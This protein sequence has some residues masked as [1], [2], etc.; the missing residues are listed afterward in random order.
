VKGL[1]L[2]DPQ[3][4]LD[5]GYYY[6]DGKDGRVFAT[7]DE[8]DAWRQAHG[9]VH[10]GAP[11]VAI[12]FFK[13]AYYTGDAGWLNAI[14]AE[15]E[16]QG[17]EAIPI[18]GYPGPVAFHKLLLDAEGKPAA[19]VGLGANFQFVDTEASKILEKVDIPAINII[20]LYGRS[21]KEWRASK[22]GLS[23][24]EG[25]FNLASPE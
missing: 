1:D 24:F 5:F 14:I 22:Q 20:T 19:D 6:P 16:K 4:A 21:E 17:G 11:R 12:G 18:F 25:T 15:I 23:D 2:P 9:K 7:W 13:A 10:P 8:F 3:P